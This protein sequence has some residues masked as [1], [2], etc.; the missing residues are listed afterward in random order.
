MEQR[1]AYY[2][3]PLLK[4]NRSPLTPSTVTGSWA[5]ALPSRPAFSLK[6]C[7]K[8]HQGWLHPAACPLSSFFFFLARPRRL[9]KGGVA[10]GRLKLHS[11]H[12]SISSSESQREVGEQLE[13]EWE[14]EERKEE[15]EREEKKTKQNKQGLSP[16]REWQTSLHNA[17]HSSKSLAQKEEKNKTTK[18]QKHIITVQSSCQ[19]HCFARKTLAHLGF[20]P[21]SQEAR[22]G[23]WVCAEAPSVPSAS[24]WLAATR[25]LALVA[26]YFSPCCAFL[27]CCPLPKV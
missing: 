4:I 27:N 17:C 24:L 13:K 16:A 10:T 23:T 6:S 15:R 19:G 1:V 2:D 25:V 3:S 22:T 26:F 11:S 21:S 14:E 8:C 9:P 18:T 7:E 12:R 20:C 5:G